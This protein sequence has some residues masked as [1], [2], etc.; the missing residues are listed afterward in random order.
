VGG[1]AVD[2]GEKGGGVCQ[3]DRDIPLSSLISRRGGKAV[4]ETGRAV[5]SAVRVENI[6]VKPKSS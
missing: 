3:Y 2:G 1:K 5:V 4:G 6:L